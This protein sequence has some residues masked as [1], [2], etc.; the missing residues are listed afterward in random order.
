[1]GLRIMHYR[2]NL[3]GGSLDIKATGLHGTRVMCSV[4]LA[5]KRKPLSSTKARPSPASRT[6]AEA[7][8][9]G[10]DGPTQPSA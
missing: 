7:R 8:A 4:P 5:G 9:P 1:M 3:I 10:S 6:A 2:A